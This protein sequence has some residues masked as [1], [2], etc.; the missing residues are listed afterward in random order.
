MK[1]R[2]KTYHAE[3]RALERYGFKMHSQ[4]FEEIAN[5]IKKG[6]ARLINKSPVG[7][8]LYHVYHRKEWMKVVY[9]QDRQTIISILPLYSDKQELLMHEKIQDLE[10]TV[11][12]VCLRELMIS[13]KLW[14][15]YHESE[16]VWI[17]GICFYA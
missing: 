10:K 11:G 17:V 9:S 4:E 1:T 2:H 7:K 3:Q 8:N 13:M 15:L 5:K 14:F 6:R 12:N 16:K